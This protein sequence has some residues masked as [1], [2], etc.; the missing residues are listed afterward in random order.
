VSGALREATAAAARDGSHDVLSVVDRQLMAAGIEIRKWRLLFNAVVRE[1]D[2]LRRAR[3]AAALKSRERHQRRE[4]QLAHWKA[5]S[6]DD[7]IARLEDA[8][9]R[10]VTLQSHYAR[11]LNAYDGGT[12]LSFENAAAWMARLDA[13]EVASTPALTSEEVLNG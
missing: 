6:I 11:L 8:L 10:S 9:E 3:R 2:H 4:A 5:D 7:L 12:R 1:V 13:L